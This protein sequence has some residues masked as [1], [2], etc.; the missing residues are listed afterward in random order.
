[1]LNIS[2]QEFSFSSEFLLLPYWVGCI[3]G[4]DPF[5][6]TEPE[7][8]APTYFTKLFSWGVAHKRADFVFFVFLT[9]PRKGHLEWKFPF[10]VFGSFLLDG[11]I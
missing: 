4:Y 5:I 3:I 9:L 6:H 7:N 8:H 11:L 2:K 1:M 10:L